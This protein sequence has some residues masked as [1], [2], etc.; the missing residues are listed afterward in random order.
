[1]SLFRSLILRQTIT[2]IFLLMGLLTHS[3]EVFACQLMGNQLQFICC[4]AQ[5]VVDGCEMGGGCGA[6]ASDGYAAADCCEVSVVNVPSFQA[7]SSASSHLLLT[8]LDR[9]QPPPGIF[10]P[11]PIDIALSRR[12]LIHPKHHFRPFW[13]PGNRTYLLTHRL[14]N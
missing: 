1:M 12:F 6:S 3:Q 4:C 5:P 10:P 7:P 14:R 9:P 13:F 8:L 2:A 11:V